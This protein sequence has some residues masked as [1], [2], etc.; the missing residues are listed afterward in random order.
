MGFG[1]VTPLIL[2]LGFAYGKSE[3]IPCASSPYSSQCTDNSNLFPCL[4]LYS[5][6][7]RFEVF[8]CCRRHQ[9]QTEGRLEGVNVTV[10]NFSVKVNKFS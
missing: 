10:R 9:R 1:V 3:H 8:S 4:Y 6:L 2:N 5:C 7:W